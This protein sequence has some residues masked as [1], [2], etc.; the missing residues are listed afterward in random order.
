MIIR[1]F[2]GKPNK[3]GLES[4]KHLK[5]VQKFSKQGLKDLVDVGPFLDVIETS[6]CVL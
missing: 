3:S 2:S 1:I 4:L 6:Q 5:K